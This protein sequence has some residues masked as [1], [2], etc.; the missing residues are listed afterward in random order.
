MTA[1]EN[2]LIFPFTKEPML[3]SLPTL[4]DRA[5]N[6]SWFDKTISFN[7]STATS[8]DDTYSTA[9]SYRVR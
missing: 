7:S 5:L 1:V 2:R 9:D 6:V 4:S 8:R 3:L